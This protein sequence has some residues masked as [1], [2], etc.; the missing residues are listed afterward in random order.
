MKPLNEM[1]I[2][3]LEFELWRLKQAPYDEMDHDKMGAIAYEIKE[4]AYI[5]I[6]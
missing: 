3:E 5:E 1:S 2:T 4:R 6:E